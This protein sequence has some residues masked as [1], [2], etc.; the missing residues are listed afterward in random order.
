MSRLLAGQGR[1]RARGRDVGSAGASAARAL[2]RRGSGE[3]AD[4]RR[5]LAP[6]PDVE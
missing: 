5:Q 1:T 2:C 4:Q 6:P 3:Q